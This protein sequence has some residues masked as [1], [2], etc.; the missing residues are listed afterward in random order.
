MA[1]VYIGL[2]SN[3]E[4]RG[5]GPAGQLDRALKTI[6]EHPM[7]NL[8]AVSQ[9][10]QTRAIGPENQPDYINA[11]ARLDTDMSALDLLDYLQHIEHEQGRVRTIRW[12]A[13]TLD[14][15]ILLYDRQ[16]INSERLTVPHP[17]MHERAFVLAPL[18]DLQPNMVLPNGENILKLLANCS[19]QGI[20]KL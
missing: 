8:M 12:G 1:D 17:R 5:T 9:R 19:D 2:G 18:S 13:R 6:S 4:D 20:V 11:A 14:L 3:L 10:Y 7:I 16:T 15:D